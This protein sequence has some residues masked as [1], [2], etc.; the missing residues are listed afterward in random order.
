MVKKKSILKKI[1]E[2]IALD[3]R[4]TVYRFQWRCRRLG[5]PIWGVQCKQTE[6]MEGVITPK[7]KFIP[8]GKPYSRLFFLGRIK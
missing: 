5:L 4:K 7:G 3:F 1:V 8:Y 2:F 6:N